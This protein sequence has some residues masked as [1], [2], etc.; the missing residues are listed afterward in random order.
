MYTFIVDTY[1]SIL[2]FFSFFW[3]PITFTNFLAELSG[4]FFDFLSFMAGKFIFASSMT[5]NSE[6]IQKMYTFIVDTYFSILVFFSFFLDSNYLYKLFGE[7][8]GPFFRFFVLYG[9]KIHFLLSNLAIFAKTKEILTKSM[10]C[11]RKYRTFYQKFFDLLTS[12]NAF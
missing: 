11:G 3:I 4:H 5:T 9:R 6:K 8:I 1:F 12:R 2:F 10:V 7:P